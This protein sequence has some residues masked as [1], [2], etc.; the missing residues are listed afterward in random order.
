MFRTSWPWGKVKSSPGFINS[1]PP[2]EARRAFGGQREKQAGGHMGQDKKFAVNAWVTLRIKLDK[3]DKYTVEDVLCMNYATA[4]HEMKKA[5]IAG[6][7]SV[8]VIPA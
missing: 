8:E 7:L 6:A 1:L 3:L 5:F 4:E 2:T